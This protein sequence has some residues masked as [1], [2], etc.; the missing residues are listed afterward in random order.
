MLYEDNAGE[1]DDIW[2]QL[3]LLEYASCEAM[4][5]NCSKILE[6]VEAKMEK[7][8]EDQILKNIRSTISLNIYRISFH[9]I[10]F[11]TAFL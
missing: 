7:R 5:L 8:D 6:C 1:N 10:S 4:L 2:F 9:D 11:I 3:N